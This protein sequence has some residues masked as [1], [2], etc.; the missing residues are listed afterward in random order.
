M[1]W[2]KCDFQMQTPGD[3]HNWCHDDPAY[4]GANYSP[5]ELEHS[6]EMY[7]TRCHEVDLQ[8]ICVTDHNFIGREYL[9]T[10]QRKNHSVSSRLGKK[11]LV[12]FPGFEIEISQGL[13]VHLLCIFNHDKPLQDIDDIV[14]SIGLHRSGRVKDGNIVPAQIIFQ[15]FARIIQNDHNGIIV[16]AHPTSESGFL[17][18]NFITTHFQ[19]EMFTSPHL[20]AMEVPK[21]LEALSR[22]WRKMITADSSCHREW[23]RHRRIAA[24]MSSDAYRLTEG[25]KGHIGKRATWMKM[26]NP[27]IDS[28]KQAFLDCERINLQTNSP[29]NDINHDRILSLT[30]N[31]TAFLQDQKIYLSPNLNCIIGG[32]GSGKSSILEYIRLCSCHGEDLKQNDQISR[33][34]NTFQD[35]TTIQLEWRYKNGLNDVFEYSKSD[36]SPRIIQREV[37]EPKAILRNLNVEVLSQREITQLAQEQSSLARLIDKLTGHELEHLK[38]LEINLISEI[39]QLQQTKNRNER[40]IA[41]RKV[42]LQERDELKRQ[43]DAFVAVRLENERKLKANQAQ[44]YIDD[45]LQESITLSTTWI[46]QVNTFVSQHADIVT[47]DW[48]ET[49]YFTKLNEGLISA[50]NRFKDDLASSIKNYTDSI[51]LLTVNND[52]WGFIAASIEETETNFIIACTEQGLRPEELELLK[53]TEASL[54]IKDKQLDE[55]E[56]QLRSFSQDI[57]LLYKKIEHLHENWLTQTNL[58]GNKIN[59]IL[60][61]GDVPMVTTETPFISVEILYSKDLDHFSTIWNDTQIKRNTRL[62]RNWE[63]IGRHLFTQFIELQEPSPWVLLNKWCDHSQLMPVDIQTLHPELLNYLQQDQRTFWDGLQTKKV[64]DRINITLFRS[65]GTRAGSLDDN[66]LSDG[67]KN[68][69]IL[70]LLFAHGN[71]PIIIDQP[72]DE[73]DSDFIYNELVPLLRRVK[74]KRQIILS[75]HNANIPVNGDSELVYAINAHMGRG[76]I[77]AEGGLETP[78]VRDTVLHI[79]EGSEEAFKRRREKYSF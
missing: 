50:K 52:A 22:N 79:M 41:E 26:S 17:N 69:A 76:M 44:K 15:D 37:Q 61:S 35:N 6:V 70:A 1:R 58:K 51:N 4:L 32:R 16:A 24:V 34:K 75:T 43:W 66:G 54:A 49:D 40:L 62:G 2:F 60:F 55:K 19:Q 10:L 59:E 20:L 73:L 71:N 77:K 23:K 65:D 64:N 67:Q 78:N 14:T 8:V 13:G 28:I 63:E 42:I 46:E 5:E 72:E 48:I 30:I 57:E 25:D 29:S 11:P 45:I 36:H 38:S 9:E 27:S 56:E 12:I 21:P 39:Q 33:I 47:Q 18:D 31:N 74:Y 68:T 53:V 3:Y 7:L